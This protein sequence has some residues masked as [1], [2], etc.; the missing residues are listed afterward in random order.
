MTKPTEQPEYK[1]ANRVGS[2]ANGANPEQ[3]NQSAMI[4]EQ[5]D[6]NTY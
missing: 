5:I 1:S 6:E 3:P 2:D 4:F